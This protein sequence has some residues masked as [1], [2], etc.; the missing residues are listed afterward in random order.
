MESTLLAG[1]KSKKEKKKRRIYRGSSSR[2]GRSRICSCVLHGLAW[3]CNMYVCMY[4]WERFATHSDPQIY[5]LW[6]GEVKVYV[7][8]LVPGRIEICPGSD[9]SAR[10]RQDSTDSIYCSISFQYFTL[11]FRRHSYEGRSSTTCVVF[12]MFRKRK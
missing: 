6:P 7:P 12:E 1:G 9:N 10:V 8:S 11:I 3:S 2:T 5:L 4:V